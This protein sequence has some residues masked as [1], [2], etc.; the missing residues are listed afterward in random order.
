M[1]QPI[2]VHHKANLDGQAHPP[3]SLKMIQASLEANAAFIEVDIV[4]LA[5]DDYLILHDHALDSE[6]TGQGIADEYTV[7][8]AT[9]LH[10]KAYPD[11]KVALLSEVVDLF[12]QSSTKT[13]LQLDFKNVIPFP[14]D[15]P[16][17]RLVALVKPL[18]KQVIISS[19]ADWQLRKLHRLSPTVDLGFD[20]LFYFDYR[21]PSGQYPPQIPPF[22]QGAYGYYDDGLVARQQIWPAADYLLDRCEELSRRV[23]KISVMYINYRTL[24]QSLEDGF[25]WVE[26][27]GKHEIAVAAWTVDIGKIEDYLIQQLVNAGV[28]YITTNTPIGLKEILQR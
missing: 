6:T 18:G 28:A 22:K 27:L 15:E 10:F 25:N 23:P 5:E 16:L 12:Q 3:N 26:Y 24:L 2:I 14:T 11:H 21:H 9:S 17:Q 1:Q 19:C 4:A 8:Q 13:R 20:P 7:E